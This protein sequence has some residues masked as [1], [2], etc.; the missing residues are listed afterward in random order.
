ML[1]K[2]PH[3][4]ALRLRCPKC[5]QGKLFRGWFHMNSECDSCGLSFEREAGFFL[6]SIYVNYGV[7]ALT[8]VISYLVLVMVFKL[9]AKPVVFGCVVFTTLFPLWFF[10]YAR[11]VFL[12]IDHYVS[13]GNYHA[14]PTGS[15][16]AA[17]SEN[18][19][20]VGQR[21]PQL[22]MVEQT[23]AMTPAEAAG[24]SEEELT[25]LHAEDAH[26]GAIVGTVV[27]LAVV[28]GLSMGSFFVFSTM[29]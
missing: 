12:T 17:A 5:G 29:R 28:F 20:R 26:A 23:A 14:R 15:S 25:M 21:Q 11:S 8:T 13:P 22:A 19:A 7:T 24:F 1:Q 18:E 6:G 10:R 4:A 9:P 2:I 27:L 16:A 3:I